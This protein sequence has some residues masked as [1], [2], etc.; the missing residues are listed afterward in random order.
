MAKYMTKDHKDGVDK[1][2]MF[3]IKN[4]SDLDKYRQ[5]TD[6]YNSR[7]NVL[8]SLVGKDAAMWILN[9]LALTQCTK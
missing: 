2:K 6:P 4:T 5:E 1:L 3:G 7:Y 8:A 9:D